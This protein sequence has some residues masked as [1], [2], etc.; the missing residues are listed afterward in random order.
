MNTSPDKWDD[1]DR[2]SRGNDRD[3]ADPAQQPEIRA[4]VKKRI[5]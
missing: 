3:A 4:G 2:R 5:K 1:V